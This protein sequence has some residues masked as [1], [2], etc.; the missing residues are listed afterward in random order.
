MHPVG[1]CTSR[2]Q[3]VMEEPEIKGLRLT[4]DGF[5]QQDSNP[6][7]RTDL[8]GEFLWDYALRRRSV[9]FD[10]G[11]LMTHETADKLTET[12]K[13]HILKTPPPGYRK[14]TWAQMRSADQAL[15]T[16]VQRKCEGGVKTKPGK[17]ETAF[18]TAWKEAA[19]DYDVRQHLC[20]L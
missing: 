10:I 14:V 8:S 20:F 17:S 15:W 9:A 11:G 13:E 1:K 2:D 3:E 4:K 12:L 18:E 19:F 7:G 16:L 6:D 5:F